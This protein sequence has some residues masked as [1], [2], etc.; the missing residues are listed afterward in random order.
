MNTPWRPLRVLL[1]DDSA[2]VRKLARD[3]IDADERLEVVGIAPSI[4]RAR[5]AM[6]AGGPDVLLVDQNL[7]DGNGVELIRELMSTSPIPT[8]LF[9]GSVD[10]D[11]RRQALRVGA[12]AVVQKPSSLNQQPGFWTGLC[13]TLREAAQTRLR[14]LPPPGGAPR[15][16]G[17]AI[18][19]GGPPVV[20]RIL[21]ELPA[22]LPP[23]VVVQHMRDGFIQQFAHQLDRVTPIRVVVAEHRQVLRPGWCYIAP[24]RHQTRV[25]PM[26]RA[27]SIHLGPPEPISGHVPSGDALLYS[28]AFGVGG[29]SVGAVLTGIGAD[30]AAGLLA[31]RRAGAQTFAQDEATSTVFGMPRVAAEYGAAGRV[32][33]LEGIASALQ[34]TALVR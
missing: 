9:S 34:S 2:L 24:G 3:H 6:I 10:P 4:S 15:V 25:I 22:S 11:L 13:R 27:L 21:S 26:G 33:P 18:S 31:M 19:T 5:D 28:I 16:I 20:R 14:F 32:V 30:G 8:V 23:I 12:V 7:G 17:I 29:A 1:V